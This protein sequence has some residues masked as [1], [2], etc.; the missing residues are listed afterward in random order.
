MHRELH[1]ERVCRQH[2]CEKEMRRVGGD[3]VH[4]ADQRV[5]LELAHGHAWRPVRHRE[6]RRLVYAVVIERKERRGR[7]RVRRRVRVVPQHDLCGRKE[8]RL[9][10][11]NQRD[12]RRIPQRHSVCKPARRRKA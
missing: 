4:A 3:G 6:R 5:H 9:A 12:K 2:H 1:E 11:T 7:R 8:R 10:P